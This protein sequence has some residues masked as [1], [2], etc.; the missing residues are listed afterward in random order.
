MS[1]TAIVLQAR[2]GSS[3]LP[4][5][6]LMR[7]GSRTIL[8]HCLVRLAISRVPIIV[9]TTTASE[10][11]QIEQ[12][13]RLYGAEVFRGHPTDVLE[14]FLSVSEMYGLMEIVRATADNPFVDVGGPL[15]VIEFRRRLDAD[16]V[17]EQGLPIGMAVE[18]VAVSALKRASRLISDPYD[19]EHVTSFIRRD[20]RFRVFW[21][22]GPGNL[23]RPALRLTVD[24]RADLEFARSI[25][26]RIE[27]ADDPASSDCV[28]EAAGA[29][30]LSQRQLNQGIYATR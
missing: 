21:I 14:R 12:E 30:L 15:R 19:R 2:L 6:A 11:D 16:H 25:Q 1:S 3:R 28:I 17:T 22:M 10:D 23:R 8:G 9:A 5:K 4:S 26:E 18:A 27:T 20:R 13:A 7:L 24:T 29:L